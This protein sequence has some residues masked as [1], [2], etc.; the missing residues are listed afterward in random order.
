MNVIPPFHMFDPE[1]DVL[2]FDGTCLDDGMVVMLEDYC[3]RAQ[4]CDGG[5]P[6]MYIHQWLTVTRTVIKWVDEEVHFV[7]RYDDGYQTK[8]MIPLNYAWLAKKTSVKP[9]HDIGPREK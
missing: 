4:L 6:S 1:T 3:A 2:I 7:A 5:L 8:F 9:G